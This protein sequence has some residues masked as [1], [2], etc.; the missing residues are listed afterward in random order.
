MNRQS[1]LFFLVIA[2][3][4][5][6]GQAQIITPVESRQGMLDGMQVTLANV[7]REAGD[8]RD[9]P[10]PF[11]V[12][13]KK[14]PEPVATK[15]LDDV[16][17]DTGTGAVLED[18]IALGIISRQFNP[19]GSLVMGDRG[20]LQLANGQTISEGDSFK[21]EIKGVVYEI[22]ISDVTSKSY[23]LRLGSATIEKNFLTTT[24]TTQ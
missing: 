5:S 18:N 11:V 12:R 23:Q 2:L 9:V 22:H 13:R 1:I 3:A 20:I 16:P 21:A 14:A 7:D 24:G 15:E 6:A 17:V 19:L 10:S 4:A 8:Y